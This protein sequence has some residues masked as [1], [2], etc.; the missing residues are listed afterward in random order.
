MELP[1][2]VANSEGVL[3]KKMALLFIMLRPKN[4]DVLVQA[5][6]NE[7]GNGEKNMVYAR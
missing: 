6:E 2:Q 1:E 5:T 3:G 4:V 7:K